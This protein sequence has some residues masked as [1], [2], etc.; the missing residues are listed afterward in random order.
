[1]WLLGCCKKLKVLI[2]ILDWYFSYFLY[3]RHEKNRDFY[4]DLSPVRSTEHNLYLYGE[5]D[6]Y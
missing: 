2:N 1:M 6:C 3:N 5:R 4:V